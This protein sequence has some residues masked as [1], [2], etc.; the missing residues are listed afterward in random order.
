MIRQVLIT[1][2][3]FLC[4]NYLRI[5][6]ATTFCQPEMHGNIEICLDWFCSHV[7]AF[8]NYINGKMSATIL[9][10]FKDGKN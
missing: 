7:T 1:F 10:F 6:G 3:H 5:T 2:P 8:I 4:Q 9:K